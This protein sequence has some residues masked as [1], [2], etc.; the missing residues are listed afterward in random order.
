M[1]VNSLGLSDLNFGE[2]QLIM[3][4][5][6]IAVSSK[7]SG[8]SKEV[9]SVDGKLLVRSQIISQSPV[10]IPRTNQIQLFKITDSSGMVKIVAGYLID[11][12]YL[13]EW[14]VLA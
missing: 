9:F 10:S 13:I 11:T 8:F 14:I 6:F 3:K 2:V 5:D 12:N 4:D 7:E 1:N